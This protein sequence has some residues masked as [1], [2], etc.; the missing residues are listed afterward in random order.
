MQILRSDLNIDFTGKRRIAMAISA[1]MVLASLALF[2]IRGPTWGIDFTGGTEIR[3][4]FKEST[5]IGEL[6]AALSDLKLGSD[7]VQQIG[8]ASENEFVIRIQD[9]TYGSDEVQQQVRQKL[10]AAF[11]EQWIQESSFDAQVGARMSVRYGGPAVPLTSIEQALAGI[12]GVRVREGIDENTVSI[13]LPGLSTKVEQAIR[14][15][16]AGRLFEIRNVDSV[17]P[18]VGAELRQQGAVAILATLGLILVYVAF[19]F[20]LIFAPG[21]VIALAH[22]VILTVGVFIVFDMIGWT[23]EFNLS[24]I[25][26]LLTIVGYSLNDTIVIY[27]RIRENMERYRRRDLEALINTSINETLNRTIGTSATTIVAM[28]AFLFLGGPVIETF[29]LAIILGIVFGTYSTIFIASPIILMMEAIRPKVE[30]FFAPALGQA[31]KGGA[32]PEPAEEPAL[33]AA[34]GEGRAEA[35]PGLAVQGLSAS[36]Q[37]RRERQARR[38]GK[39]RDGE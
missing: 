38:D 29:A 24:M 9:T 6:R 10:A 20:K 11:G 12:E 31:D 27:D 3:L 26:A 15:E 21:A 35:S 8:A 2:F 16:L 25:G 19:R 4:Q 37:R 32:A 17:G 34:G 14:G 1:I 28:F 7:A 23:H 30:A 33:A 5:E 18:K 39:L 13:D 36:E 22:D